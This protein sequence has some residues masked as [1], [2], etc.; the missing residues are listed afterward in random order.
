MPARNRLA[1]GAFAALAATHASAQPYAPPDA[2]LTPVAPEQ[3]LHLL[4]V[5]ANADPVMKLLMTGLLIAAVVAIVVW[6][7]QALR[8][9][10]G[11]LAR[12]GGAIAYL[13]AVGAA[14]PLI[15]FFGS[16][17]TLLNSALALSNL[18][19]APTISVVAP[20][21][22][23]A[24]LSAALGLL[25]AAIAT[26]GHRHLKA[27]LYSLETAAPVTEPAPA[28]PSRMLRAS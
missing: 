17:Y 25:A 3:R 16:A 24:L 26:I 12:A 9:R 21:L 18:R 14:G 2:I 22:A 13:S 19:P 4:A 6:V 1:F 11:G 27:K 5:F 10:A 20:G 15:G 8:L 23:E 7:G 28:P